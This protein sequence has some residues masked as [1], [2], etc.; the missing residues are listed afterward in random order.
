MTTPQTPPTSTSVNGK[1]AKHSSPPNLSEE[2][3]LSGMQDQEKLTRNRKKLKRDRRELCSPKDV[4]TDMSQMTKEHEGNR[5]EVPLPQ[6]EKGPI[7]KQKKRNSKPPSF[8]AVTNEEVYIEV[9]FSEPP[10]LPLISKERETDTLL[11]PELEREQSVSVNGED[12]AATDTPSFPKS[13]SVIDETKRSLTY[14]HLPVLSC[15]RNNSYHL[16]KLR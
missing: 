1:K 13:K 5:Y 6:K 3:L 2:K 12:P 15:S 10:K 9:P 14:S 7:Q 8:K 11:L 4:V 16:G